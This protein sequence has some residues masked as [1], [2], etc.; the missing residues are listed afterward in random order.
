M[1]FDLENQYKALVA[2]VDEAGRGPLAGDVVASCV[3]IHQ[4]KFPKAM[5]PLIR[6]SKQL[7]RKKRSF[8]FEELIHHPSIEVT[9]GTAS[10]DEIDDINILQA[11]FLAM[12]R[13]IEKIQNP[14]ATL[15]IDGN[16]CPQGP[17]MRIPLIR[18]DQVCFSISLASIFAKETRDR[19]MDKLHEEF[20]VYGWSKNAGYPTK[21]HKEAIKKYGLTKYHRKSFRVE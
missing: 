9:I 10:V 12:N 11:T 14:I 21:S 20:P 19:L 8:I 1:T 4:E 17:F 16:Q 2:G 18:G 13:A 6:D 5:I 15:L 3:I 7:S